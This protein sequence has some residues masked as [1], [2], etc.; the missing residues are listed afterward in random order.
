MIPVSSICRRKEIPEEEEEIGP[1]LFEHCNNGADCIHEEEEEGT[2]STGKHKD[3][4][5]QLQDMKAKHL[6]KFSFI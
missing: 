1:L 3:K 2:Q 6:P 4:T 5:N